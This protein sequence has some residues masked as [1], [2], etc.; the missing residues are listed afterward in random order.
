MKIKTKMV[1]TIQASESGWLCDGGNASSFSGNQKNHHGDDGD[2]QETHF[3]TPF[4]S[5]LSLSNC[6]SLD[7]SHH[8]H[9]LSTESA[10]PMTSS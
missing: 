10:T 8:H 7:H 1:L 2:H 3:H 6:L 4:L 5:L 9:F